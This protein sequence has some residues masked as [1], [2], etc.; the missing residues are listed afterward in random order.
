VE[1]TSSI[2]L[3]LAYILVAVM[4]WQ[5]YRAFRPK[6]KEPKPHRDQGDFPDD[7]SWASPDESSGHHHDSFSDHWGGDDG[8][9][10]H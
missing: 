3:F 6:R 7:G 5:L 8:G 2:L 10:H 1:S 4:V 9:G